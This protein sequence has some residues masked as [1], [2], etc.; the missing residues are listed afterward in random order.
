MSCGT[1]LAAKWAG[2]ASIPVVAT[3]GLVFGLNVST[4]LIFREKRCKKIDHMLYDVAVACLN[5][6]VACGIAILVI[7]PDNAN[8]DCQSRVA[9]ALSVSCFLVL[10]GSLLLGT[11]ARLVGR[12]EARV[13]Y[14]IVANSLLAFSTAVA[15]WICVA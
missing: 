12:E 8:L 7:V 11:V 5:S 1:L 4:T 9:V 6:I 14:L 2:V 10:G 3:F 15:S 13:A